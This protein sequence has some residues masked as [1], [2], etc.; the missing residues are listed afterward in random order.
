MKKS[1]RASLVQVSWDI[2]EPICCILANIDIFFG[3][4]FFLL[5]GVTFSPA[6][7]VDST[8]KNRRK[9]H[10]AKHGIDVQK[11]EEYQRLK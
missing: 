10:L 3:Y 7:W 4:Y 2:M 11:Y 8:V 1:G 6:N 9:R 5:K